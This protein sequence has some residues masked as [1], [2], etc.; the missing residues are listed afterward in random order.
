MPASLTWAFALAHV[1]LGE[2][3]P[4]I[5]PSIPAAFPLVMAFVVVLCWSHVVEQCDD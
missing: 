1:V 5:P 4:Q 3:I 2:S